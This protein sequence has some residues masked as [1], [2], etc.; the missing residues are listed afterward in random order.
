MQKVSYL[1]FV[2]FF[3]IIFVNC[4]GTTDSQVDPNAENDTSVVKNEF[5]CSHL[6]ENCVDDGMEGYECDE[7]Y[8]FGCYK[9]TYTSEIKYKTF[10][11]NVQSQAEVIPKFSKPISPILFTSDYF[12]I[13]IIT[14][15]D[16][17]FLKAD[18]GH[19]CVQEQW[20]ELDNCSG[21]KTED[22]MF[23]K[24]R[25]INLLQDTIIFSITSVK[26]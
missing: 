15:P 13:Q 6:S 17:H 26:N 12:D 7:Y 23:M 14:S 22:S 1:I 5:L 4:N 24:I 8:Y 9:G 25:A 20:Y 10:L 11:I 16:F 18:S 21:Y 3:I 2:Y 19:I